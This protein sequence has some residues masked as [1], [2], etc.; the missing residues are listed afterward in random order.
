[1]KA[2]RRDDADNFARDIAFL[3]VAAS[4]IRRFPIGSSPGKYLSAIA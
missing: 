3:V 4:T 1:M 2:H